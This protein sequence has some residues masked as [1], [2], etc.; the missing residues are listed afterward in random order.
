MKKLLTFLLFLSFS[1]CFSQIDWYKNYIKSDSAISY[2]EKFQQSR[3]SEEKMKFV[4][5]AIEIEPNNFFLYSMK[6]QLYYNDNAAY[7][8]LIIE[9]TKKFPNEGEAFY[10]LGFYQ[11]DQGEFESANKNYEIALT[12][13][14]DDNILSDYNMQPFYKM[15]TLLLLNRKNDAKKLVDGFPEGKNKDFYISYF[16]VLSSI[17][18]RKLHNFIKNELK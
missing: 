12:K 9:L 15:M 18:R 10:T 8:K 14:T 5:R 11:E 1:L 17:E 13:F 3:I 7:E 2:Y 6:S 16:T 4:N